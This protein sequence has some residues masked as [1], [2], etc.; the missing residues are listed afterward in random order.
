MAG[1]NTVIAVQTPC[2]GLEFYWNLNGTNMW[3][4]EQVAP[5]G[6]T[7]SAP[8]I[9]QDG[10]GVV[11]AAEGASNSLDFY[12]QQIGAQGWQEEYVGKPRSTY[13][14]PSLAVTD[15]GVNIVAR[16]QGTAWTP[17]GR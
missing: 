5:A 6:T 14:A 15:D 2:D 7:F 11:I 10:N 3:R 16:A 8:T 12:W 4:S 17:G 1:G 13:S 9:A